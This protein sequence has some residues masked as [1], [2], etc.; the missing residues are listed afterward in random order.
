MSG[1][2]QQQQQEQHSSS[3]SKVEVRFPYLK[4]ARLQINIDD[5]S[6][7]EGLFDTVQ[8]LNEHLIFTNGIMFNI[9]KLVKPA[10][11]TGEKFFSFVK[12]IVPLS[13]QPVLIQTNAKNFGSK[14]HHHHSFNVSVPLKVGRTETF[15]KKLKDAQK[16]K[17]IS[18]FLDE[19]FIFETKSKCTLTPQKRKLMEEVSTLTCMPF[20]V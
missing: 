12:M 6:S 19:P 5:L 18:E 15:E 1:D 10:K 2:E 4:K 20:N 14:L 16:R 13:I 17:N 7:A 3:S 8:R 9:R 11:L